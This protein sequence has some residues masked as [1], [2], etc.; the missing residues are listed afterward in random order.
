M[1]HRFDLV[2]DSLGRVSAARTM[3]EIHGCLNA[4]T[5][6]M[7]FGDYSHYI[8]RSPTGT[9]QTHVLSSYP[10]EWKRQYKVADYLSIDPIVKFAVNK[11][12]P[13]EWSDALD[14]SSLDSKQMAFYE[15]AKHAG[16]SVGASIPLRG[17]GQ[18]VATF[19][20]V[21]SERQDLFSKLWKEH[22]HTLHMLACY[23]HEKMV[24]LAYAESDLRKQQLS[25]R[26]RECLL[27]AARG[28]SAWEIG[29]ILKLSKS[30]ID[31]YSANAC[32][33]MGVKNRI[34][35]VVLAIMSG[36]IEI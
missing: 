25:P 35:A 21:L 19:S 8:V 20:I 1:G 29:E 12:T 10:E 3:A 14:N 22:K 9:K 30:T 36:Q 17:H 2:E 28:K 11:V 27:W 31:E 4:I 13:Y 7:G 24:P 18:C 15:E 16:F 23:A 26:E 34:Q 5:H 6:N 32:R 33:K